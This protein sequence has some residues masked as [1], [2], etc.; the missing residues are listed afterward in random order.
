MLGSQH[1][2]VLA[3]EVKNVITLMHKWLWLRQD[4]KGVDGV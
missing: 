4:I 3:Y 2:C 1:V